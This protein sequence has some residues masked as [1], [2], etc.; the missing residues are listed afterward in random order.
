MSATSSSIARVPLVDRTAATGT[1][2]A[3]LDQV[4][5][6]IFES[7]RSKQLAVE[8]D[9]EA[10]PLWVQGDV[11]RFRQALLNLASNAVK[12][13]TSG[14]ITIRARL[15]ARSAGT[16]TIRAEVQA[17]VEAVQ[18]TG[19]LLFINDHWEAALH[20]G[21]YGIH[22]GQEDLDALPAGALQRIRSSGTRLGK[23]GRAHV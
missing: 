17:A 12:F 14:S 6:I 10:A 1:V 22:I 5:S 8:V 15:T 21:A 4:R 16:L 7:A 2:R 3:V 9:C 18:G 13:T 11:T 23:I 20:A 19:A